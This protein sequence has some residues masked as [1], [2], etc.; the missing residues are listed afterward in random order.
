MDPWNL[1]DPTSAA[2]CLLR[3][4]NEVIH[5]ESFRVAMDSVDAVGIVYFARF[6]DWYEH[7]F[8]GFIAQASGRSW[9]D[10]LASG[11]AMPLVRC[12]IDYLAPLRLSE[13]VKV[14]LAVVH[15]GSRSVQF[16]ARFRREDVLVAKARAVHVA[17]GEGM[18]ATDI[19]EWLKQ[20]V[21]ESPF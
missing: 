19:P 6:W 1:E 10:L 17:V 18:S 11:S 15:T 13:M 3:G 12:E 16:A 2:C 7:C 8:E 9:A 14:D 5:S 20:A 4:S 21:E